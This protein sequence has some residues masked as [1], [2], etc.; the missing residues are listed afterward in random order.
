VNALARIL[1]VAGVSTVV[2]NMMPLWGERLGAPRTLGVEFPFGHP[3]GLP[4]DVGLQSRVVRA[5]LALLAAPGPPPVVEHFPE[6]W[7]GNFDEWRRR[8]HP[9]RPSPFIRWLRE[10]NEARRGGRQ[11]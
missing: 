8:W 2:I 7:P 9:P 6:P 3:C 1:E 11:P 4:D 5:A 10:R